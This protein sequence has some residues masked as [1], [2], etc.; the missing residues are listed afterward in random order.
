MPLNPFEHHRPASLAEALELLDRHRGDV[1]PIAGGTELLVALKAKVLQYG[2]LVDIKRIAEMAGVRR[3]ADGSLRIGA[4]CSHHQLA[5]HELVRAEIPSYAELS[6]KV[7]NIRVRVAGTIG[8][9]LCFAEPHADPPALLSALEAQVCLAGRGG[10]RR[11]P[12][13]EFIQSEFETA[14]AEDELLVAI[15]IPPRPGGARFK[16]MSYGHLE[17]PAV[18]VAAGLVEEGAM[19]A[20]RIWVGA[21]CGAPTRLS[22]MEAA[23]R[24]VAPSQLEDVL[25]AAA[26]HAAAQLPA[27]GDIHGSADYKQHLASVYLKRTLRA[28]AAGGV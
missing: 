26:D 20:Y 23:L 11:L 2:H 21:I 10:E 28:V 22:A 7:A 13:S 5:Q 6:N 25:T 15:T 9:N 24:G 18:G 12:V 19:P 17:R 3:E 14:R 4:L 16:Y 1:S 8:G 27:H